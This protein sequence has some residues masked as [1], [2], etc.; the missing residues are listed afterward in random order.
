LMELRG[1]GSLLLSID[2]CGACGG[3]ALGP[4]TDREPRQ[5]EIVESDSA[6]PTRDPRNLGVW[7]RELP[8]RSFSER[9]LV[10]ISD[11]LEEAGVGLHALSG[12]VV[13]AGP[14]S[15][16]GIRIGISAV[17]GLA[18]GLRLPVIPVSRLELLVRKAAGGNAV[19]V[20]GAGRS[21]FFVG[22]Y[23]AGLPVLEV[24][25]TR[26]ELV[27]LVTDSSSSSERRLPLLACEEQVLAA[28][29]DL[30]PKR[31]AAPTA[32][33]AWVLGAERLLAGRF[34]DVATLDANY[35]RRSETEMLARI[36]SHLALKATGRDSSRE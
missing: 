23:R 20:L 18:E 7:Y 24:L 4:V 12:I 21:E 29:A 26:E 28:L 22:I 33:D 25:A 14:G 16:T 5:T 27:K 8:G 19:A 1:A 34:E 10:S 9:L 31:V 11:L 15:F 13:V 35:L 17:K 32:V 6:T 30:D 2:T 3:V 36:A